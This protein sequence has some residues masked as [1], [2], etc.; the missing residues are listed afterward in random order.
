MSTDMDEIDAP[1]WCKGFMCV[2]Y[3][4]VYTC[5][6]EGSILCDDIY[7]V[8]GGHV[9]DQLY[10]EVDEIPV[11]HRKVLEILVRCRDYPFDLQTYKLNPGVYVCHNGDDAMPIDLALICFLQAKG[12]SQY[13]E[14]CD[15]D[16]VPLD[17]SPIE[18]Q[19][20]RQHLK[21]CISPTGLLISGRYPPLV[22]KL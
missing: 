20:S 14:P 3:R 4:K 8:A 11:A 7:N 5:Y 19:M 22:K 15:D 16:D 1:E 9:L 13:V 6:S 2:V 17:S 21:Y 10:D 12:Y 18:I